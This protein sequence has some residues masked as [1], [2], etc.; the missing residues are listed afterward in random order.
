MQLCVLD[1]SHSPTLGCDPCTTRPVLFALVS[2]PWH[3]QVLSKGE[4][5]TQI[6]SYRNHTFCVSASVHCDCHDAGM[7]RVQLHSYY[8]TP[9]TGVTREERGLSYK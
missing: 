5:I 8:S 6:G 1:V 9:D 7:Y 2:V 4:V 3:L